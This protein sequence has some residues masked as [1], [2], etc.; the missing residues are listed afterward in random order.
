MHLQF[1]WSF[2]FLLVKCFSVNPAACHEK[3]SRSL[4]SLKHGGRLHWIYWNHAP[5]TQLSVE[6][7]LLQLAFKKKFFYPY[8]PLHIWATEMYPLKAFGSWN[9]FRRGHWV[10]F[11]H[12]D[13]T[14]PLA[15]GP[16]LLFFPYPRS[17]IFLCVTCAHSQTTSRPSKMATSDIGQSQCLH[18]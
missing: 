14:N 13:T 9:I 3:S 18:S 1:I 17:F 12:D 8:V 7:I 6:W 5:P 2:G 4:L 15:W 11:L 10:A 16:N